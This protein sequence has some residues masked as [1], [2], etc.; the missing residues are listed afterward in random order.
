MELCLPITSS[1]TIEELGNPAPQRVADISG[2]EATDDENDEENLDDEKEED[3]Y[4][5]EA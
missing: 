3:M 1:G 5:D 2:Q 4:I